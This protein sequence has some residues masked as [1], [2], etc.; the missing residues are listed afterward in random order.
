MACTVKRKRRRASLAAAISFAA[1]W[2]MGAFADDPPPLPPF[3]C[4][5]GVGAFRP[6]KEEYWFGLTSV[7]MA[8]PGSV[9]IGPN[10]IVF[11]N[12]RGTKLRY[13]G[14]W[15]LEP[16]RIFD[17]DPDQF[18]EHPNLCGAV[19][20]LE[21]PFT[22]SL[23]HRNYLCSHAGQPMPAVYMVAYVYKANE[24]PDSADSGYRLILEFYGAAPDLEAEAGGRPRADHCHSYKFGRV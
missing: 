21:P 5:N 6:E 2:G 10:K 18:K 1:A 12:G 7:G 8:I 3:G 22:R 4:E 17:P 23:L 11:Q 14:D 9:T 16:T 19:Y 15:T 20:A 24:E 13:L